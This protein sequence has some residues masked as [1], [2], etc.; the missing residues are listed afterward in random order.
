MLYG[1]AL[2]RPVYPLI[3]YYIKLETYKEQCVNKATPEKQCNGQCILMQKLR[4][5]NAAEQEPE[6][7]VPP[8]IQPDDYLIGFLDSPSEYLVLST[9]NAASTVFRPGFS[10]Q[11]FVADLFQPP[12][13]V[14]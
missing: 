8:K 3:D 10:P 6:A 7:P 14:N 2:I 1:I 5:V 13:L 11:E 4:A 12:R 9:D